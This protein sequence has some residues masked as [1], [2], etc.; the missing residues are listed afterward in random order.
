MDSDWVNRAGILA[1]AVSFFL[2]APEILGEERLRGAQRFL[3]VRLEDPHEVTSRLARLFSFVLLSGA[4]VASVVGLTVADL[5]IPRRVLMLGA[6]LTPAPIF[7]GLA[8]FFELQVAVG[9]AQ[10][11]IERYARRTL[12]RRRAPLAFS[13]RLFVTLSTFVLSL[14]EVAALFGVAA[15]GPVLALLSLGFTIAFVL[16]SNVLYIPLMLALGLLRA[17]G[18]LRV[19]LFCTGAILLLG[20]LGAELYASFSTAEGRFPGA[21]TPCAFQV[22]AGYLACAMSSGS[23]ATGSGAGGSPGL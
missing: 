7:G 8:L 18:G 22:S 6:V 12:F 9:E 11:Y 1:E 4:F 16:L 15:C 10:A 23:S 13:Q 21:P 20:G 19:V 2:I 5:G 14:V 17:P 3:R